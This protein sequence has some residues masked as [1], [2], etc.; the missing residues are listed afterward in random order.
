MTQAL[1][2]PKQRRYRR[3]HRLV[4][5]LKSGRYQGISNVVSNP[6]V[7]TTAPGKNHR[8]TQSNW[9]SKFKEPDSENS[10]LVYHWCIKQKLQLAASEDVLGL[11]CGCGCVTEAG[12]ASGLNLTGEHRKNGKGHVD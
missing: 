9:V 4:M 1:D 8:G 3:H 5:T 11:G 6:Q 7:L 10:Q 12:G 2:K